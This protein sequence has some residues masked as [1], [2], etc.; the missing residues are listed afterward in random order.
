MG[1]AVVTMDDHDRVLRPG[2]VDVVGDRIAWVGPPEDAPP[3]RA[4]VSPVGGLLMPGLVNTHSHSS[5]TLLRGGGNVDG[6]PLDRW[7]RESV[8][9]REAALQGEDVYWGTLLGVHELLRGGVTTTSE[10]YLHSREVALAALDGGIR[11]VVTPGIFDLPGAD[12]GWASALDEAGA[13]HAELHG[14]DGRVTVGLGPHSAYALPPEGL[15]ATARVAAELGAPVHVHVAETVGEGAMVEEVHG[16]RVP[17]LLAR[18]GLFDGPVVAAHSVWLDQTDLDLY[19]RH[20]VAVAH[21]PRSNGRLGSGVARVAEMLGRGIRV[22]LGTDGPASTGDLDLWQEVRL[23]PLLARGTA[24][25][26]EVMST[27]QAL[28]LATRGGADALG[29]PT[30]SL[31]AGRLA[32][33]VRLDLDD[34]SFIPALDPDDLLSHLVWAAPSRLVTDVWVGGRQVVAAGR[35]VTVDGTA[36]R[37]EVAQRSRRLV[38]DARPA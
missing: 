27:G 22:G 29:V 23:A 10:M 11:C 2:I 6:L 24:A 32:D 5:M 33:L 21:C 20:D 19:A 25:D 4:P 37:D 13:L 31:Q 7:L 8:W 9:P 30:G 15:A 35:C 14:R 38:R 28:R 18:L 17:E 12:G 16:C 36:A 26:P 1:D 34:S 3:S